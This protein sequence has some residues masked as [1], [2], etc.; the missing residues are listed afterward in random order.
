LFQFS[1]LIFRKD[2]YGVF[3]LVMQR[4]GPKKRD[5]KRQEKSFFPQL[6]WQKVFDMYFPQ[7]AF[8]GVFEV[9]LLRN[10]QKC[11]KKLKN[12]RRREVPTYLYTSLSEICFLRRLL[13]YSQVVLGS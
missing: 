10:A 4:N 1:G 5:K 8:Y 12:K 3:E 6:F 11:Q 2:F 9:P 7:K 13:V